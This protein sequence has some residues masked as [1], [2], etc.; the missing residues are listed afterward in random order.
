MDLA[1]AIKTIETGIIMRTGISEVI[2]NPKLRII[3]G[4]IRLP[5]DTDTS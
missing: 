2:F 4:M 1:A 3:T 5:A